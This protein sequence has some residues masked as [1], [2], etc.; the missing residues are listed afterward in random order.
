MK[1]FLD[2]RDQLERELEGSSNAAIEL[3]NKVEKLKKK[4]DKVKELNEKVFSI[5]A[6]RNTLKRSD[7]KDTK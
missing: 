7:Y 4:S 5:E 1:R 2:K 6:E 3:I